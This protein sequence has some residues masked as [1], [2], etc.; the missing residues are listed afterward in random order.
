VFAGE[1]LAGGKLENADAR[2]RDAERW[3]GGGKCNCI[4][5]RRPRRHA[6]GSRAPVVKLA[7]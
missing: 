1:L 5:E 4:P 6:S 3:P 2:L 7:I